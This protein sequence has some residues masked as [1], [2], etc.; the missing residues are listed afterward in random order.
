MT[1]ARKLFGFPSL[2]LAAAVE[3]LA[4]IKLFPDYYGTQSH[5]AAV[6]TL[7]CANWAFGLVFWTLVY[8]RLLSPLRRIPGPR[9]SHAPRVLGDRTLVGF[10][11]DLVYFKAY[12]SAVFRALVV[13]GR[14]SGD[15]FIDIAKEYPG[16]D[17]ITLNVLRDQIAVTNPRLMADLLVHRCYDFSKPKRTSSF[18]R[19]V[20]GDGLI[21]VEEDQHK[22]LRKITTPAFHYRHIKELYPMMWAKGESLT[23]ALKEDMKLSGTSTIELNSWASKVTLD[24]IGIAGL[25]RKFDAVEQG[26]DPLAG[27]Y[28]QLLE[29]SREKIVFSMLCLAIG[30]STMSMIP[31]R[32][33]KVFD[34]LTGQLDDICR[35][36]IKEKR[37]AIAEKGDDHFD[38]LSLLMKSGDFSDDALK[39]QLLTFLA[40]GYAFILLSLSGYV[41]TM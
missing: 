8:P 19:Y 21:I 20:L 18:L 15:L 4:A 12:I 16:E 6:G 25:G 5:L 10:V 7:L 40:A 41:L 35:A 22:S 9:V 3:A 36:M 1:V 38:V 27:I 31:W 11:A 37:V 26:H 14:P 34:H 33:N 32:M 2:T 24:I 28:E 17:L 23:K 39:D 13:K 29:P 30:R